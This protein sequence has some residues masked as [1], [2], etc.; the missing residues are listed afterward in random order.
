MLRAPFFE[1]LGLARVLKVEH[2]LLAAL[3][4][5]PFVGFGEAREENHSPKTL[6]DPRH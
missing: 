3:I 1:D 6:S 4:F 2:A 5:L